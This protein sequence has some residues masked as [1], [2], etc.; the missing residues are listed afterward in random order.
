[1]RQDHAADHFRLG[2]G[3]MGTSC[4]RTTRVLCPS[5]FKSSEESEARWHALRGNHARYRGHDASRLRGEL[6]S[7][8][9]IMAKSE[10]AHASKWS[11]G[12]ASTVNLSPEFA[13]QHIGKVRRSRMSHQHR[14]C[15]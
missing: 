3:M 8:L 10:R 1:M 5:C 2:A 9:C 7:E 14:E 13:V 6:D 12:A 11:A 4:S 15:R